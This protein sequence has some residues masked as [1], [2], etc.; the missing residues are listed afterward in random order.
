MD[1]SRVMAQAY[2]PPVTT[3][4]ALSFTQVSACKATERL[5]KKRECWYKQALHNK[6]MLISGA[7]VQCKKKEEKKGTRAELSDEANHSS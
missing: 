6:P 7:K 1:T 4:M 2:S 3:E 5:K